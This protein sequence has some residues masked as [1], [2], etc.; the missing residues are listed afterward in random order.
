MISKCCVLVLLAKLV[1]KYMWEAMIDGDKILII[2]PIDEWC[3]VLSFCEDDSL[4]DE[5]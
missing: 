1:S 3:G 4:I 2:H 5:R